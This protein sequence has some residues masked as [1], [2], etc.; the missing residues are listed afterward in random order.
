MR[1]AVV[2]VVFVLSLFPLPIRHDLEAQRI[3]TARPAGPQG[4][5]R[6]DAIGSRAPTLQLGV[7]ANVPAG[8]Y[9]RLGLLAAGGRA[10]HDG[11][12]RS[13]AR[14]D[15]TIR[16]LLDPFRESRV[17][18]YGIGGVSAMYDGFE[19]WRARLLVGFGL[20]GPASRR[21]SPSLEVVLG[22]GL[23]LGVVVRRSGAGRR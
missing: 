14:A 11:S 3:P 4:E 9:V 12:S 21:L 23:R 18:L 22:G 7:A 13:A 6:V 16:F 1:T 8:I 20:E 10:W 15:A 2:V 5:L 19:K 17:G